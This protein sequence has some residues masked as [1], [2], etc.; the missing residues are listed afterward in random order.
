MHATKSLVVGMKAL[1]LPSVYLGFHFIKLVQMDLSA[2][3]L[4]FWHWLP[5]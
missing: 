3:E 1:L 2:Q 4:V 5:A